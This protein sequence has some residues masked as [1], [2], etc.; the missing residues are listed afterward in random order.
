MRMSFSNE[1][2]NRVY[3]GDTRGKIAILLERSDAYPSMVFSVPLYVLGY[4]EGI[5]PRKS[6]REGLTYLNLEKN[7]SPTRYPHRAKL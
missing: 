1:F 7:R 6:F 5:Y 3:I 2:G 4:E